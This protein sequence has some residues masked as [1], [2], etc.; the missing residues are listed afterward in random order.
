MARVSQK[1]IDVGLGQFGSLHKKQIF[2]AMTNCFCN[3]VEQK[4][5][6]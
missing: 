1:N 4:K 6:V 5:C 2:Q 3:F